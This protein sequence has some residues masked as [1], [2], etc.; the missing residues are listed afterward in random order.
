M[1]RLRIYFLNAFLFSDTKAVA[2]CGR[3]APPSPPHFV[4]FADFAMC[5]FLSRSTTHAVGLRA[6][7]RAEKYG[8]VGILFVGQ[9]VCVCGVAIATR[10]HLLLL[11][12]YSHRRGLTR[13]GSSRRRI[14][15]ACGTWNDLTALRQ[16]TQVQPIW[17]RKFLRL[18]ADAPYGSVS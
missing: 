3:Y 6:M 11:Q 7:L 1:P 9:Y 4:L 13:T 2:L 15:T 16:S 5:L 17:L 14:T 12:P 18:G 8:R 10:D